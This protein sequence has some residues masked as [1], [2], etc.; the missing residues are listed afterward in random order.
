MP[1][2]DPKVEIAFLVRGA[3][4]GEQGDY[5]TVMRKTVAGISQRPGDLLII[6]V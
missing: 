3:A 1:Q 5:G 2:D 6:C 4:H